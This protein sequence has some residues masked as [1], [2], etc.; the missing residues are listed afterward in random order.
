MHS[1]N[2]K[3]YELRLIAK[4]LE[5]ASDKYA[6]HSCGDLPDDFFDML[7]EDQKDELCKNL[8]QFGM[9][10]I[11]VEDVPLNFYSD[12]SLMYYYADKLKSIL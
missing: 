5:M 2:M 3:T 10:G 9:E 6:N 12:S 4:L 11:G 7:S 1:C 8:N